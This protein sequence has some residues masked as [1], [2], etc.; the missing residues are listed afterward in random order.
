[1]W[2]RW[3]T[4]MTLRRSTVLVGDCQAVR[5][6]ARSYDLPDKRIFT[7]PWGIDLDRF[8]P[9]AT[10]S[11]PPH[12]LRDRLGWQDAFVVLSLR[13]WEPVYGIDVLL[14]GFARAAEQA[15]E[16][17]LLMMGGGSQ[18]GLVH[19]MIRQ[20]DLA[21]RVYLGGQ[22]SQSDLPQIYQA[23]DLY[24][25]ASHSDGSSVSLME[26]LGCGLPV[27]LSDI[28]SN[29]EWVSSGDQGWFF[30]DGDD[31]SLA[32]I[33]LQAVQNRADLP[34]MGRAA[35]RQAEK[36]ADWKQNFQVLRQAYSAA[37]KMILKSQKGPL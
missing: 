3:V 32:N 23:A 8:A 10:S 36:R 2:Y 30:P 9:A 34:R 29:R 26:A 7:F 18:A 1:V 15:P 35:R 37:A 33:L 14:R 17:R 16:L 19:Q 13:S 24:I 28:P 25:S 31:G 20:H 12:L 6:C 11:L 4:R 27:L 5:D 22:M 21:D